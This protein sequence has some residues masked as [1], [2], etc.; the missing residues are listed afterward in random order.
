MLFKEF[1]AEKKYSEKGSVRNGQ[2]NFEDNSSF[3]PHHFE[4][5]QQQ[6]QPQ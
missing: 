2:P 3:G 6:Q 1:E 4:K 5:N